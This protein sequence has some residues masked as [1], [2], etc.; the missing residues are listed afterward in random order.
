M[1]GQTRLMFRFKYLYRFAGILDLENF[2]FFEVENLPLISVYLR[3]NRKIY[4]KLGEGL[5]FS[6]LNRFENFLPLRNGINPCFIPL[7]ST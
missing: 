1:G 5:P 4:R 2:E 7:C 6:E 3:I